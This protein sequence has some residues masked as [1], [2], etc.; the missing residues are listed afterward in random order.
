M[1][2]EHA[3]FHALTKAVPALRPMQHLLDEGA[4]KLVGK[5]KSLVNRPDSFHVCR[6]TSIGLHGEFDEIKGHDE[7]NERLRLVQAASGGKEAYAHRV[8]SRIGRK[9][10]ALAS[11]RHHSYWESAAGGGPRKRLDWMEKGADALGGAAVEGVHLTII[12]LNQ[13]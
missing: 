7:V 2:A 1:S 12:R 8:W 10:D 11:D 5:S 13:L 9:D 6:Q 3:F 4:L